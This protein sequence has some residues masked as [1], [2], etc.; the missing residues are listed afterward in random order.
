MNLVPVIQSSI[1][2]QPSSTDDSHVAFLK[3][4]PF[5]KNGQSGPCPSGLAPQSKRPSIS[6]SGGKPPQPTLS[7]AR[8]YFYAYCAYDPGGMIGECTF[9]MDAVVSLLYA[10]PDIGFISGEAIDPDGN[11]YGVFYGGGLYSINLDNGLLTF[12]ANTI[13]LNGMT[14]DTTT[15]M[16]YVSGGSPDGLNI[17]DI[18]TGATTY[19]GSYGI[20]NIM[21]SIFCDKEGN[22]YGYDVLFGGNSHL[23]SIDKNTG[24]ATIIGDMGHNFCYAQDGVI[25]RNDDTCYLAAYDYGMGQSYL[26]TCD[27]S[28]AAVTIINQFSPTGIEID[29]F[30]G[31][32]YTL[33][34]LQDD[35]GVSKIL[36]PTSGVAG[37]ITPKVTV[38]NYG[39]NSEYS[40]PV[41]M[42]IV[43][44]NYTD[45]MYEHFDG[46][47]PLAGWSNMQTSDYWVQSS[48]NYAGGSSPEAVLWYYNNYNG[49]GGLQSGY[50]DTSSATSL[51]LTFRS[52]I[53]YWG[54]PCSCTVEVTGDGGTTWNDI[55]PWPNPITTNQGPKLY[56]IDI[57][58]YIGTQT[59]V[60][61]TYSGQYY[62]LYYWAI[63][64]VRMFKMDQIPEYDQTIYTDIFV[65]Q[66]L[67][68]TFPDWTPADLGVSENVNLEYVVNTT[69]ELPSDNNT[70]NDYKQ[71]TLHLYYGYFNDIAITDIPSPK[72][73]PAATQTPV[74]NISNNG[75]NNE[76]ISVNMVIGKA[77]TTILLQEDFSSG[78]PPTGWGTD[79]PLNWMSSPTNYAGGVAP[80]ACFY[81]YPSS[82]G[83]F[84]LYS[85]AIDTTGWTS[86]L[87]KFKEYVN[88]YNSQYTLKIQTQW[89]GSGGWVDAYSRAGGPY[90]PTETQITLGTANGV[91]ASDLQVSWTFS[92]NSYNI[93]Y[94]YIDDV[95]FG[96]ITIEPEYNQTVSVN[97]DA[98]A[99]TN[100]TLPDWTPEDIPFETDIDYVIEA[101]ASMNVTDG[102]PTDN[103]QTKLITLTYEH[104]V[105]VTEIIIESSGYPGTY[106]PV[107]IVKNFGVIFSENNIPVNAKITHIDNWTV[108]YDQD[109]TVPG[110]LAPNETTQ[111]TFQDFNTSGWAGL[112]RLEIKT[113]LPGDDHPENDKK[114]LTFEFPP[115]PPPP[116]ETTASLSGIMG[117]NGWYVSNVTITLSVNAEYC[118]TYYKIDDGAWNQYFTPFIV[119]EDGYHIVYFHSVG[120]GGWEDIKNI[121]F[122]I[123]R[124]APSISM[125]VEKVGFEK[126]RFTTDASDETSGMNR[127]ACLV[128]GDLLGNITAPGPYQWNWTGHGNHTVFAIAYDNAGNSAMSN[129]V[130][131]NELTFDAQPAVQNQLL[132]I[133]QS[134]LRQ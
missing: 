96:Q 38:K 131:T 62:W 55:S 88:D 39:N 71:K 98:G 120:L 90:G 15:G 33:V 86:A 79:A 66:S 76:N 37:V 74:V 107:G 60:R 26:A 34:K 105:G 106:H 92:G 52:Y 49:Q 111:V 104:D 108:I 30:A 103:E 93:N 64:D 112:Y 59:G 47:F 18:N 95:W 97:C 8:G 5:E 110:P 125:T 133:R 54:G 89:T 57:S 129:Q 12:I 28:T 75:Q 130:Q 109:I 102:N 122:K 84:H 44:N 119:S 123:D 61:F 126:W 124:T 65:D 48:D 35:V 101:S 3:K 14:L 6:T 94:W 85:G 13:P 67:N 31:P 40:V 81:W 127:V 58:A 10:A 118:E 27:L 121:S 113:E 9:D 72:S 45:Y 24:A 46:T 23:Y 82:V 68:V 51:T 132:V 2:K 100:V 128:D 134:L 117:L 114:T 17:I 69:T 1:S 50:V 29:G 63:D 73:G 19:V 99:S 91:G 87:L 116:P 77:S 36:A 20:S 22:M 16:Y 25:D 80:E 56:S 41:N 11:C 42:K 115:P 4:S 53:Y 83:D 32:Y 43:K 78:V 70:N 7:G 21:I